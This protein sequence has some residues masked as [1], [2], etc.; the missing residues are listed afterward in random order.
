MYSMG[1]TI[2]RTNNSGLMFTSAYGGLPDT[3]IIK[4]EAGK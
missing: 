4:E 1:E 3:K 2:A